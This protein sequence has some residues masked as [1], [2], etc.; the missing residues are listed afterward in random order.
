MIDKVKS[1]SAFDKDYLIMVLDHSSVRVFSSCC[2]FFELYKA[3]LYHTE[4]LEK[5]RKKYPR[6]DAI[7]F[8]SPTKRS[9]MRLIEDFKSSKDKSGQASN[10]ATQHGTQKREE[11]EEFD[12]RP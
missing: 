12:N 6:T 8:I 5:D 10:K 2:Q 11:G 3:G 4:I 1:Q 9:I 7:Y